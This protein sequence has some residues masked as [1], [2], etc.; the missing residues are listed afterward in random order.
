VANPSDEETVRRYCQ[1]EAANDHDA[2]S[3]LRG[4]GLVA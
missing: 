4:P 1:A 3:A 2:A